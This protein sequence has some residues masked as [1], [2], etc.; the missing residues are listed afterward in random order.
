M[1]YQFKDESSDRKYYTIIPNYILNHSSAID[2]A[3]YIDIKRKAGENGRCFM[4][5]QTMCKRNGIG[6]KQLHKSLKYLIEHKWIK[7]VGM[8]PAKT[9]P[10]KTYVILDIWKK[11][12]DFYH[13]QKISPKSILSKDKVQK[14]KDSV[15]KSSKIR[16]ESNSI[17]RTNIKEE[18]IKKKSKYSSL[19]DLSEKDFQEIA[20]KYNVG[21]SFVRSSFDDLENYCGAHGR[22]YKNYRRAL[23][24]FV[25]KDAQKNGAK[26]KSIVLTSAYKQEITMSPEERVKSLKKLDEVRKK[27]TDNLV[28]DK[29]KK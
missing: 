2:K 22:R 13:N 18:P 12:V 9:R 10:I 24:N 5:E 27:L 6:K 23:M 29:K 4:A 17:R 21:I 8:T 20:K 7:F 1:K 26:K 14:E 19:F 16:A 15:P 28:L 3:I 11:N 25:K